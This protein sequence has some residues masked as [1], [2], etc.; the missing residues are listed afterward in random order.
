VQESL[1]IESDESNN[2]MSPIF[3]SSDEISL[4][5]EEAEKEQKREKFLDFIVGVHPCLFCVGFKKRR[6]NGTDSILKSIKIAIIHQRLEK[7]HS[8]SQAVFNIRMIND[9]I[10]AIP[11]RLVA[12]FKDFLY[13]DDPTE[14]LRRWYS[15]KETIWRMP[16]IHNFLQNKKK[17]T[18]G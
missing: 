13:F 3:S 16:K 15:L 7:A 18:I 12:I 10:C 9:I 4:I 5:T 14:Y 1:N 11:T 2:R 6:L 8:I 17:E